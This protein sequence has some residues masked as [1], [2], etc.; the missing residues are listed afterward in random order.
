LFITSLLAAHLFLRTPWK[1]TVF[2][3]VVLPLG[4]LRNGFR[5]YT[6]GELCIHIGPQMI[7]SPIHRKGGPIFFVLSLIPLFILLVMLQ[8]SERGGGNPNS[9]TGNTHNQNF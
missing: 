6:I 3:L 4:I 2:V 8:K 5:V 7:N 1:R 9:R